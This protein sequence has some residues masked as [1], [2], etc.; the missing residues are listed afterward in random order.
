MNTAFHNPYLTS[1]FY[2]LKEI[3]KI[4]KWYK[5]MDKFIAFIITGKLTFYIFLASCVELLM[6]SS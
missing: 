2:T 6:E 4:R 5:I 1:L 3:K